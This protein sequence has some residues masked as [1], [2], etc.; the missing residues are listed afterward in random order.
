MS[1]KVVSS[2]VALHTGA[3]ARVRNL[4]VDLATPEQ[5]GLVNHALE[6]RALGAR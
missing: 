4:H 5:P 2:R 1:S 3:G 6:Q